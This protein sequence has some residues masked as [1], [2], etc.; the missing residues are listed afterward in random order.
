MSQKEALTIFSL[1]SEFKAYFTY[2]TCIDDA[3]ET[4]ASLLDVHTVKI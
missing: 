2:E 1:K 4:G 3:Q